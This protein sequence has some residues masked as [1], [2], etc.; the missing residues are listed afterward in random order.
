MQITLRPITI[1]DSEHIVKWRN[2]PDVKQ[3]L[4]SQDNISI[5]QQRDYYQ[6]YI[7]TKKI[8]QYIVIA[9]GIECGTTFLKK[10]DNKNRC[11][12]FGIF[13]G[14]SSLRGRGIGTISTIKTVEIGFNQ[15]HLDRIY[16][17]VFSSNISAIRSYEKAGFKITKNGLKHSLSN[18]EIV[19]IT[20]MEIR[21]K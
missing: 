8:F 17:T 12:E 13:I 18:G 1:E 7:E 19:D 4:Y 14:E 3:N 15:L 10:L 5:N 20:E 6:K 16:L 2:C 11:A 9:D 21:S